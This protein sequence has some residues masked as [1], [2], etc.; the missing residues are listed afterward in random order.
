V[1]AVGVDPVGNDDVGIVEVAGR[2]A[3]SRLGDGDP[4]VDPLRVGAKPAPGRPV[5]DAAAGRGVERPHDQCARPRALDREQRKGRA[6][7]FVHVH[8]VVVTPLEELPELVAQAAAD[9]D[10][11]EG[12]EVGDQDVAADAM[13]LAATERRLRVARGDHVDLVAEP[14][15]LGRRVMDVL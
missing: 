6:Q 1:E 4:H 14:S 7:W 12:P 10:V 11:R 2:E 15:Q 5:G 8:D 13:H 3:A 9:R